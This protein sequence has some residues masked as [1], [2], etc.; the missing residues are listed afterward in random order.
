[1]RVSFEG[2]MTITYLKT[3][4]VNTR[5]KRVLQEVLIGKDFGEIILEH[6]HHWDLGWLVVSLGYGILLPTPS[7]ELRAL[8]ALL[9]RKA[10]YLH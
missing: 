1:M 9:L 8:S 4:R 3:G 10:C 5:R 7:W 2:S 6:I